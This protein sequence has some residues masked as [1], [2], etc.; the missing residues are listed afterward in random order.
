MEAPD[1]LRR[2]WP[3][4][5]W[6]REWEALTPTDRRRVYYA[7]LLSLLVVLVSLVLL[8]VW[9]RLQPRAVV[10]PGDGA[11]P[12]TGESVPPLTALVEQSRDLARRGVQAVVPSWTDEQPLTF[13]ILGVDR[14]GE[15]GTAQ[16]RH[17]RSQHSSG[18]A[19]R[20]A[21]LGTP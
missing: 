2:L 3:P 8:V 9:Q 18:R 4:T 15:E 11:V 12:A 19:A 6:R 13:L 10:P 17:Y 16:R 5:A 7:S 20:H 14:R 1:L 21:H